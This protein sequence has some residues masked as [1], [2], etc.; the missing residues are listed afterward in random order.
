LQL[1]HELLECFKLELVLLPRSA[2]EGRAGVIFIEL[3]GRLL[4]QIL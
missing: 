2:D 3:A 1:S 4:S